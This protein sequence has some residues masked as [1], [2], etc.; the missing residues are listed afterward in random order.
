[1]RNL[2]E[3]R[4]EKRADWRRQVMEKLEEDGEMYA[5]LEIREFGKNDDYIWTED[6]WEN[7]LD[8]PEPIFFDGKL[9]FNNIKNNIKK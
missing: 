3:I 8:F 1:M 6:E 9:G 2:D 7:D 4:E 5:N